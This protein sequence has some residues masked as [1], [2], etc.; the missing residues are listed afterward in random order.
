MPSVGGLVP[1]TWG[2]ADRVGNGRR[3]G[4]RAL[5]QADN[6]ALPHVGAAAVPA[7]RLC[8]VD[9]NFL[10]GDAIL[11]GDAG[12]RIAAMYW[13]R[14]ARPVRVRLRPVVWQ[15]PGRTADVLAGNEGP[16]KVL[17][18]VVALKVVAR[19]ATFNYQ[20]WTPFEVLYLNSA[21]LAFCP[22]L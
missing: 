20:L 19:D 8:I 21:T 14:L 6:D 9:R 13:P 17:S 22:A 7:Q 12:A 4:R 5:G 10:R 11:R 15:F 3:H 1:G 16:P 18:G 2:T